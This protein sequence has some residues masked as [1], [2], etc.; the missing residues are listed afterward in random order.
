MLAARR[1][2]GAQGCWELILTCWG[3]CDLCVELFCHKIFQN[4]LYVPQI[5]KSPTPH[6][7]GSCEFSW[8]SEYQ[9]ISEGEMKERC[10]ALPPHAQSSPPPSLQKVSLVATSSRGSTRLPLWPIQTSD[11]L[12]PSPP[13]QNPPIKSRLQ[14]LQLPCSAK[15]L[16][17]VILS[18][19]V[20]L[21]GNRLVLCLAASDMTPEM[22]MKAW[23]F[24]R[25][26]RC[27]RRFSPGE[28]K[29][30]GGAG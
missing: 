15:A 11:P 6:K 7:S 28:G 30:R 26:G 24:S 12:H 8:Q 4:Y 16:S 18:G 17:R 13:L 14:A 20:G 23:I 19:S 9:L 10:T 29:T 2:N 21:Q 1:G 22:E 25:R 3:S 5:L 27:P